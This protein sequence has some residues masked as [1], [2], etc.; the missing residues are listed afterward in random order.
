MW[1]MSMMRNGNGYVADKLFIYI[2]VSLTGPDPNALSRYPWAVGKIVSR[3][4]WIE[5]KWNRHSIR[6][7]NPSRLP[8]EMQE[9]LSI[10]NSNGENIIHLLHSS[11]DLIRALNRLIREGKITIQ[12]SNE[13]S[14]D[15][16]STNFQI[17]IILIHLFRF[18]SSTFAYQI[19]NISRNRLQKHFRN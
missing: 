16:Y 4:N 18:K 19:L 5:Y 12:I 7:L 9:S 10:N 15:F 17:M 1:A 13:Y 8:L 14:S 11:T 3:F 2:P 6:S